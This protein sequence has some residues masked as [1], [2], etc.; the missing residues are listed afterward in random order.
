MLRKCYLPVIKL[1]FFK[2]VLQGAYEKK[3]QSMLEI[4]AAYNEACNT[5][6]QWE[7]REL[8]Y[9]VKVTKNRVRPCSAVI[10][11]LSWGCTL[12][13]CK[14]KKFSSNMV[15]SGLTI[16]PKYEAYFIRQPIH[17]DKETPNLS[18]FGL[19]MK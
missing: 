2:D 11:P 19:H 9:V 1:I 12:L 14:S 5:A 13:D 4:F 3:L 17:T 8:H 15:Q 7:F 16:K 10:Q 6:I 18:H